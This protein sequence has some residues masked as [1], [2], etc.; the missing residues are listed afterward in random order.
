MGSLIQPYQ[1]ANF[2]GYLIG[3][4]V[5]S[6]VMPAPTYT[7]TKLADGSTLKYKVTGFRTLL[8]LLALWYLCGYRFNLFNPAELADNYWSYCLI[9]N[10]FAFSLATYLYFKGTR[11]RAA[12][13]ASKDKKKTDSHHG[14]GGFISDFVMGT[15]LNPSILGLDIK[16]FILRP[17]MMG[18]MF[19]NLS[20]LDVHL[21]NYGTVSIPM[22]LYLIFS[23]AYVTD[24][25]FFEI[26]MTSTWDIVAEHTGLMLMWGDIVFIPFFFSLGN[27]HLAY[28]HTTAPEWLSGLSIG[29]FVLGY[30][31]FRQCNAQKHQFKHEPS[32]PI[33][34]SAPRVFGGRLLAS[35]WWGLARHANYLGDILMAVAYGLPSGFNSVMPWLYAIYL[36]ILL[37]HRERRDEARCSKKYNAVWEEY[38]KAVPSRIV[39]F[40]Y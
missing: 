15:E 27:F 28:V 16:L 31:I 12:A 23:T 36:T 8:L 25:F 32:K 38:C 4:G 39:P 10:I 29:V 11:A 37:V 24:Y 5:L 9:A 17:A 18:W 34:G 13:A 40:I 26:F 3:H 33:W 30:V 22:L 7:G 6:K 14:S 21:K 2:L 35:G 1:V 19:I 20:F